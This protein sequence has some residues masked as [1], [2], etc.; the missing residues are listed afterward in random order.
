MAVADILIT[1]V[2]IYR[3]PVGET[4]PSSSTIDY[5]EAWGGNW[6]NMG[7]TLESLSM[8]RDVTEYELEI[9]QSTVP[10]KRIITKETVMLETVLAEQTAANIALTMNGTSSSTAQASGVRPSEQVVAGGDPELNYYAVG[11]EGFYQDTSN[12]VWPVRVFL[13]KCTISLNGALE[14]SKS[15]AAGIPVQFKAVADTTQ[16]VGSQILKWQKV[17]G[18]AGA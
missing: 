10:V 16:A 8:S 6:T 15:K 5:L 14:F 2:Q 13:Y 4:L 3:A 17:T 11:F 18:A 7:Y 1:P 12:N 9:E